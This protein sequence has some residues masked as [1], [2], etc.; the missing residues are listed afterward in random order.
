V[1][2]EQRVRRLERIIA[3]MVNVLLAAS[4]EFKPARRRKRRAR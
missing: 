3:T 1:T 4:R 2:L